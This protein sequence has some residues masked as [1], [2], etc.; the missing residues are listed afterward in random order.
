ME[1]CD[2]RT[3]LSL[4]VPASRRIACNLGEKMPDFLL[5]F[6][7]DAT[8]ELKAMLSEIFPHAVQ[9][10]YLI[11]EFMVTVKFL[12]RVLSLKR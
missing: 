8:D 12:V 7:R 1:D 6:Y 3:A 4:I 2:F 9:V 5:P 11:F 10:S